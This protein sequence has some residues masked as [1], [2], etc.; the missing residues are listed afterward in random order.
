MSGM[1]GW[2][3]TMKIRENDSDIPII[4]VTAYASDPSKKKSLEAG[5]NDYITKPINKIKLI[6]LIDKY[7]KKS[8]IG[9]LP[10][11]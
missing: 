11:N 5:C 7:L 8:R 1:N 6:Q 2:E 3:T 4:A 10:Y 9:N